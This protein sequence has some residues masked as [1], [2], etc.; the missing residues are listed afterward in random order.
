MYHAAE[1]NKQ[2]SSDEMIQ[3]T[4]GVLPRTMRG[5]AP[6]GQFFL[7][8]M[9]MINSEDST[10]G[11]TD[12]KSQINGE[13]NVLRGLCES[14]RVTTD[15]ICDAGYK[16]SATMK[17]LSDG[18]YQMGSRAGARVAREVEAQPMTAAL[19]AA[20]LGLIVGVLLPRR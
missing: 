20:S 13:G 10:V 16:A 17:E 14:A 8:S 19:V 1:F 5:Q 12:G 6:V 15:A 3:G 18:A 9:T 11:E 2:P 4:V 7:W